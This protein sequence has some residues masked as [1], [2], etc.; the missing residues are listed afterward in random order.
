MP[1][2]S[3]LIIG[4]TTAPSALPEKGKKTANLPAVKMPQSQPLQAMDSTICDLISA[5]GVARD[6][7]DF[8]N[9]MPQTGND[10]FY[11]CGTLPLVPLL[12][13]RLGSAYACCG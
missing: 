10:L 8:P 1:F 4:G 11:R 13:F 12:P 6:E 2:D 9:S 5:V 7:G 3:V